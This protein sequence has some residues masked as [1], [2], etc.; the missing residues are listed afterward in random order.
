MEFLLDPLKQCWKKFQQKHAKAAICISI[1]TF[2][3]I[4]LSI[5][6][7]LLL[8]IPKPHTPNDSAKT[9]SPPAPHKT[10]IIIG[11]SNQVQETE[12]GD[13]NNIGIMGIIPE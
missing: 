8:T 7:P 2:I 13:I 5:T 4:V 1:A 12:N 9:D 10:T 3:V 11:D 6:V